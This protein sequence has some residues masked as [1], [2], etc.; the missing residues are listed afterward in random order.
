MRALNLLS[1]GKN[2]DMK[3]DRNIITKLVSEQTR[4]LLLEA[5]DAVPQSRLQ[6]ELRDLRLLVDRGIEEMKLWE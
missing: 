5:E 6:E 4:T 3:N 2:H 1:N